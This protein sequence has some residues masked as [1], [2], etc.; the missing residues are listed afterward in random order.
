MTG[1]SSVWLGGKESCYLFPVAQAWTSGK[2]VSGHPDFAEIWIP[3][4]H[5]GLQCITRC[6]FINQDYTQVKFQTISRKKNNW[7]RLFAGL[8]LHSNLLH[9]QHPGRVPQQRRPHARPKGGGAQAAGAC[10]DSAAVWAGGRTGHWLT[11]WTN[12]CKQLVIEEWLA[13]RWCLCFIGDEIL[14]LLLVR[15][16]EMKVFVSPLPL[17]LQAL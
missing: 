3:T 15:M 10:W 2:M 9:L 4:S 1:A 6:D 8:G 7:S 5:H 12:P 14:L 13:I 16:K 17:K 11:I